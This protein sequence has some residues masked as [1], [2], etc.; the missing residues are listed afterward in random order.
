MGAPR[1]TRDQMYIYL[2]PS[3]LLDIRFKGLIN[4]R[5]CMFFLELPSSILL[6]RAPDTMCRVSS[7]FDRAG[8]KRAEIISLPETRSS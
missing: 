3:L 6:C 2:S 7:E 1:L 4:V 5:F 8:P